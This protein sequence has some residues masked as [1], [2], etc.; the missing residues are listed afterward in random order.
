MR[1][2]LSPTI[3]VLTFVALITL[4]TAPQ[5]RADGIYYPE[6]AHPT[7]PAIPR[8]SALVVYRDGVETLIVESSLDADAQ[9]LGWVIPV[10]A[11]PSAFAQT[12]PG[13][14]RTAWHVTAPRVVHDARNMINVTLLICYVVLVPVFIFLTYGR[15]RLMSV[16]VVYLLSFLV[17]GMFTATL[18]TGGTSD[19]THSAPQIVVHSAT[20]VG[21]YDVT[22]L[23]A[24]ANV[25]LSEWLSSNGFTAP[26]AKALSIIDAYIGE[27]WVFVAAKLRR[28]EKGLSTPHP[29]SITFT[30]P[31]PVYPMRLTALSGVPLDLD[32]YVVADGRARA[33]GLG[34]DFSDILSG[35]QTVD[36]EFSPPEETWL[37]F[38]MQ[39]SGRAVG[40]PE[41]AKFLWNGCVF[42]RLSG[43]LRPDEMDKD[44]TITFS[45]PSVYA[46]R[47]YST[48]WAL[49]FAGCCAALLWTATVAGTTF[50][51]RS[52]IREA[53]EV[54]RLAAAGL[55]RPTLVAR[56]S[57]AVEAGERK[58]LALAGLRRGTLAALV[59]FAVVYAAVPT[60]PVNVLPYRYRHRLRQDAEAIDLCLLAQHEV[61]DAELTD[62]TLGDVRP[63]LGERLKAMNVQNTIAGGAV[64]EEDSP[65]NYVIYEG[66]NGIVF[67]AFGLYGMPCD[68]LLKRSDEAQHGSDQYRSCRRRHSRRGPRKSV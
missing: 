54:K 16:L 56:G 51:R 36:N 58:R 13:V 15:L 68:L 48:H 26:D 31:A 12:S 42:T 3:A 30:T 60:I 18:G 49:R 7:I 52:R 55:P 19:A 45:A 28:E 47:R 5:T 1:S 10:P 61:E 53:G 62:G 66:K 32:L 22:V 39:E 23:E 65:G 6:T 50:V 17:L 27:G 43:S 40:H 8:Q 11:V 67:R 44:V 64:R 25:A 14:L 57:F 35:P 21:S 46:P 38:T 41:L 4:A 24:K 37:H 2:R 59:A 33:R 29:L 20:I 63:F 9:S 34:R